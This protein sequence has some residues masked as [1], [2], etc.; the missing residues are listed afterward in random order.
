MSLPHNPVCVIADGGHARFVRPADDHGLQTFLA[1]DST[2]VHKHTHELVS[3]RP[4]RTAESGTAIRH[5]YAAHT[6]PHEMEKTNF[7]HFVAEQINEYAKENA[8]ETL[9][10]VAPSHILSEITAHLGQPATAKLIG[11][12]A[13]DLVKVPNHELSDHLREWVRPVHRAS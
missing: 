9:V 2:T 8:F 13:K 6:D 1:L 12:L 4:G 10:L 11:S 7:A 5:A 3:D